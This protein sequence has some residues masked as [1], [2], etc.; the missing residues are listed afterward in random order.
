VLF[1]L[2]FR[3]GSEKIRQVKSEGKYFKGLSFCAIPFTRNMSGHLRV[4]NDGNI[5]RAIMRQAMDNILPKI[6][7]V[8]LLKSTGYIQQFYALPTMYLCVL[9]LSENKQRLMSLTA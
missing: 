5:R 9:Y 1:F 8:N 4:W 3:Q 7:V 6:N 2:N